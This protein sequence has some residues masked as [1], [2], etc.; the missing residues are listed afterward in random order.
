[1]A[2]ISPQNENKKGIFLVNNNNVEATDLCVSKNFFDVFSFPLV[3]GNKNT[4]LS[5]NNDIVISDE[6][7]M[8]LFHTTDNIIGKQV[9]WSREQMSGT[10]IVS[11]VFKKIP[12]NSS[13]QFDVLFNYRA[14]LAK[15]EKLSNWKN[16]GPA[17]YIVL[18]EG[19]DPK[20]FNAKIADF[21]QKKGAR[22]TLFVQQFADRYLYGQYENGAPAGGRISYVR[23]FAVLAV[24]ILLIACINFMNLST[25]RAFTRLKEVGVKKAM[26]ADRATLALQ[27]IGESMLIAFISLLT[28]ILPLWLLLPRFNEISGKHL[29]FSFDTNMVLGILGI[30]LITGLIAGSYPAL[31]ISGFK[32]VK[33]LKGKIDIPLG[34]LWIRKGFVG[35]QFAI[36]VIMIVSVLVLYKQ[37]QLIQSK[38]LGYQR[39]NVVYFARK[40][41]ISDVK[42]DKEINIRQQE[43]ESFLQEVRN[44]PGVVSAAGFRHN[45]SAGREGGTTDVEWPGKQ[46]DA[47]IEFTDIAGGYDFI[48]T[49]GITLKEGRSY[50]RKYGNEQSKII[51][52]EAAIAAMGFTNP[53]GKTVRIWGEDK[54]IIGIVK[55][56]NFQSLYQSIHPC[57]IELNNRSSNSK[58]MVKIKEGTEAETLARL[59]RIYRQ[60][61]IGLPFEYRFLDDDYQSLYVAEKRVEV[62]SGYFAGLVIIISCLGLFGLAAFTV[63]KRY[64]EIGIRKVL[65]S[66]NMNIIWLL[67]GEFSKIIIISLLVALPISYL[68]LKNW[69]DDFAYRIDLSAWYFIAA[70]VLITIIT[71]LTVS[72]QTIK[73]IRIKPADSLR[74]E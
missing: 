12:V 9:E 58:I 7:A 46:Q 66:G 18:R 51:L 21:I 57:F 19:V 15:N 71:W 32:P 17:T 41:K 22:E 68:V 55:D 27:F 24:F 29:I 64:K 36:S 37:V 61:N 2:V 33:I 1:T 5:G 14:F 28:A 63:Q 67:W 59:Q 11:G 20:N 74:S 40:E 42:N 47:Q 45:I 23:L 25:A 48:E 3:E 16:G 50:S 43:N 62:L 73:A 26:G 54:Q 34:E 35:F 44:I 56:F 69:L 65:G 53:V 70:G 30:T 49:L 4:L 39:N 60:Y 72:S 8:K 52:N 13:L 6:L 38:N 31:Y 10:Y